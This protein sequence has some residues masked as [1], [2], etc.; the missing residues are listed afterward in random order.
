VTRGGRAPEQL[1]LLL[2]KK[3]KGRRLPGKKE[4]HSQQPQSETRACRSIQ[5]QRRKKVGS[6]YIRRL[7]GQAAGDGTDQWLES[8]GR[9]AKTGGIHR[10]PATKVRKTNPKRRSF[11][12]KYTKI[13]SVKP[14]WGNTSLLQTKKETP[15]KATAGKKVMGKGEDELMSALKDVLRNEGSGSRQTRRSL[16]RTTKATGGLCRDGRR[17]QIK[18]PGADYATPWPSL[19]RR[20]R[21]NIKTERRRRNDITSCRVNRLAQND[22]QGGTL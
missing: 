18:T 5:R 6:P 15:G 10:N 3:T 20:N 12:D 17:G 19:V 4:C 8:S 11:L 9:Q 2:E 14:E 22:L 1:T 13:R 16:K 7:E 21:G